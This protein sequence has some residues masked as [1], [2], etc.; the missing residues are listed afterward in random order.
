MAGMP[1]RRAKR[2]GH[3][4]PRGPTDWGAISGHRI[5]VGIPTRR[6]TPELEPE[7]VSD[8]KRMMGVCL[9]PGCIKYADG[10]SLCTEHRRERR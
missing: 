3:R 8:W 4:L 5:T 2:G 9:A 10:A 6:Y 1:K 7:A